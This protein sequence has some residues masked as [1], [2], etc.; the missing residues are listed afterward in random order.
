MP[1]RVM[2]PRKPHE[3]IRPTNASVE[4]KDLKG[5]SEE[6]RKVYDLIRRRFSGQPNDR[7]PLGPECPFG[8]IRPPP[9]PCSGLQVE[10]WNSMAISKSLVSP[11]MRMTKPCPSFP[12]ARRP[13]PSAS[14]PNKNSAAP[15]AATPKPR[16]S[17]GWKKKGSD[18]QPTPPSS[19]SS[20]I[21]TTE[22]VGK[23]FHAT[24]IG[25]QSP[26]S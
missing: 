17:S 23:S 5:V 15:P 20:K 9:A 12:R 19:R 24:D 13:I 6:D 8:A 1:P 3:A 26:T 2:G 11:S 4:G 25:E 16:W 14:D 10:R 22:L 7:R 21:A 18:L